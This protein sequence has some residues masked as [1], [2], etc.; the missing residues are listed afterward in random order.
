MTLAVCIMMIAVL[1]A[2][3]NAAT[4]TEA[5]AESDVT[6]SATPIETP[7][8]IEMVPVETPEPVALSHT[9]GLSYDDEYLPVMVVIENSPPARPQTGLQ[10]ADV[11]YEVPVEG[12][13]T[14]FV[15]VF[16]DNV[17]EGVMPVRSGRVSFL[18]IQ[19]E[20]D[21]LFMHFGGSGNGITTMPDYTFYGHP[22]Y[23]KI[24]I[25]IDGNYDSAV[26]PYYIRVEGVSWVHSVMMYPALVRELYDYEPEPLHWKFDSNATYSGGDG[27]QINLKMCTNDDDYVS[28]TYDPEQDV[29]LRFMNGKEFMAA[30]TDAQVAV[31]NVIVHYATYD[32]VKS[33]KDVYKVWDMTGSGDADIYIGGKLIKGSWKRESVEDETVYYDADGNQIVL[34]AGN[35][36]IHFHPY[37]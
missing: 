34:R 32:A 14:R 4:D 1:A 8:E 22:L 18:Y 5:T 25:D 35:T 20:W 10:T 16:S 9:T 33:G 15:C 28:Y 24:K 13:I 3:G 17:P 37:E 27:T 29:Y 36:W 26:A 6:P 12:S 31:K 7:T 23:K 11:V 19:Q 21:A 30:E 2:C